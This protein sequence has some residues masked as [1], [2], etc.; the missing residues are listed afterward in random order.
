MTV[1]DPGGQ[2]NPLSSFE[3]Y[4]ATHARRTYLVVST[5][6]VRHG[7]DP[8]K[9]SDDYG[10]TPALEKL[11]D[12]LTRAYEDS[13]RQP[14]PVTLRVH[15][16]NVTRTSF[17]REVLIDADPARYHRPPDGIATAPGWSPESETF[18]PGNRFYIGYRWPSEGMFSVGSLRDTVVALV[19]APAI[20]VFLLG[21]PLLGLLWAG[22]LQATLDHALPWVGGLTHAL[23]SAG[24]SLAAYLDLHSPGVASVLRVLLAP[25]LGACLSAALLGFGALLLL[26]RLSTYLRD[27]YRALQYGVPD[28][29]EFMRALEE[30]LYPRGVQLRLDVVG[31]SMG[32]LLLINAFRV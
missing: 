13:G 17:E 12:E 20:S 29:G 16:F 26:L 28:L 4:R 9:L 5:S 31:H 6:A 8:P 15:G 24:R 25:Y 1:A 27:R 11:A 30:R 7:N 22:C 21:L 32:T 18:R 2:A 14:V 10:S 19:H 3:V 23:V